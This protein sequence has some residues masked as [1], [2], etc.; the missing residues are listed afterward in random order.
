M[1]L[2]TLP[3]ATALA[4]DIFLSILFQDFF[5]QSRNGRTERRTN[6]HDGSNDAVSRKDVPFRSI[7]DVC[8]H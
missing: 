1:T 6:M 3:C 7:V 2:T 8:M 5:S 4:S